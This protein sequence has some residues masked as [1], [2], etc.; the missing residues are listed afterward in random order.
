M[1]DIGNYI[2]LI[3]VIGA[4]ISSIFKNKN[5]KKATVPIPEIEDEEEQ[6]E[7][8]RE[9]YIPKP[10]MQ[11]ITQPEK[12][13]DKTPENTI[14]S[15]DNTTDISKLKAKK[16]VVKTVTPK[17]KTVQETS[18]EQATSYSINNVNEARAAFI[19]SEIFNRKY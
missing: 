17:T 14:I 10:V 8:P 19:A 18:V 4:A 9:I 12:T 11:T 7:F 15:F 16:E 3:I 6:E 13:A 1:E 2:Y 5:K